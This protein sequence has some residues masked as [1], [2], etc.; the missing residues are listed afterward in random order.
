MGLEFISANICAYVDTP[1]VTQIS[2]LFTNVVG[3]VSA[4][5]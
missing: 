2:I 5:F 4:E 3:S 1:L